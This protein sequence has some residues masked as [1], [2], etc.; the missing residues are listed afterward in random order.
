MTILRSFS[1]F[2]P[3]IVDARLNK[4]EVWLNATVIGPVISFGISRFC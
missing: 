2:P 1:E 3:T 4:Q